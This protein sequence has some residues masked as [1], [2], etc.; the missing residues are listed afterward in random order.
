MLIG[1]VAT[2]T[3]LTVKTLRFY[4]RQDLLAAPAR[5]TGGYRDYDPTVLERLAFIKAAQASGLTLAQIGQVLAIRDDGH[6]PCD[7]VA[8]LVQQRLDDINQRLHELHTTR[9][10]LRAIAHR[11]DG[12]DPGDCTDTYCDLITHADT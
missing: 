2:R 12:Y 1:D 9:D 4:E 10:A 11:A 5:T 3:G 7:H 6:P 8:M